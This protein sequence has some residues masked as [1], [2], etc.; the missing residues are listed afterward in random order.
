MKH[1]ILS[2]AIISLITLFS[3]MTACTQND[4][5]QGNQK[6]Q[7]VATTTIVG[8]VVAQVSGNLVDLQVLLPIGS[9]PHSFDP[10]P[11]DIAK[12]AQAD[13]IFSNGAGLEEFLS[14]LIESANAQEKVVDLSRG[15]ELLET[16][17]GHNHESEGEEAELTQNEG[18]E[19]KND[20]HIGVDPHTWTNPK[21]V[22]IWVENI[23][24]ELSKTDSENAEIYQAN[25]VLY[26]TD[27]E[28]L[29]NWIRGQVSPIPENKRHLVTD[30]AM[31]GYFAEA[32][33]F[34]QV[35]ALIPGFSTLAEPSAKEL[36][37]IEDAIKALD[38]KAIFVGNTVNPSL[39]ER[40]AED[41]GIQLFFIY[42]GSLSDPGGEAATYLEYM[43]YNTTSFIE[44]LK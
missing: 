2:F 41:T 7:V 43:R 6:L 14:N 22:S 42:T 32:Y 12:V 4:P 15:I 9:D 16:G 21:N 39:A 40:V 37:E 29:D 3:G 1:R 33:G 35:W 25:A 17:N 19:T 18:S 11:Q 13:I 27:L 26:Q 34:N 5:T 8:D 10:A 23:L 36:A 20:A 44:P 30:H 28:D 38:V 31:F 24:L